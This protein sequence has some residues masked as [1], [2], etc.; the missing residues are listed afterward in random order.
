[1]YQANFGR[2]Q[3]ISFNSE[4]EYYELLGFLSK[5]NGST[6]LVWEDNDLQ[7][8]WAKEGRILFFGTPPVT[9]R[10]NL[11]HTAGVGKINSRVNCNEFILNIRN[12]HSFVL[13]E[14]Q[15]I[16]S[17]RATVP[18][19]FTADFDSGLLL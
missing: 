4:S 2:K 18:Q 16:S 10:A 6:I 8:A 3:Q 13:G 9:L 19:Q 5:S 17:I 7:G 15:D 11:L 12:D 14:E 1:M